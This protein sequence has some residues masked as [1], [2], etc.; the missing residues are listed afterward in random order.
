MDRDPNELIQVLTA[1]AT[2]ETSVSSASR[3]VIVGDAIHPM[4][5]FKGMGANQSLTDGPLLASWL[6]RASVDAAIKGFMRETA[7][8]TA[9]IVQASRQAAYEFHHGG[10]SDVNSDNVTTANSSSSVASPTDKSAIEQRENQSFAGVRPECVTNFLSALRERDVRA[11]L[12]SK[13][14]KTISRIMDELDVRVKDENSG[15]DNADAALTIKHQQAR[16]TA[17]DYARDGNTEGLRSLSLQKQTKFIRSAKT[18]EDGLGRCCLHLAV[19]GGHIETLKWLLSEVG[20]DSNCVDIN[21][22]SPI[23]VARTTMNHNPRLIQVFEC[24]KQ[25]EERTKYL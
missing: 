22:Q 12:G 18:T 23:D 20:C 15:K 9:P 5:P 3:V 10:D 14:D 11:E 7:Q 16:N 13:L 6:Q 21:N 2:V 17:L 8:R 1:L 25:H 19:L 4:S 24:M